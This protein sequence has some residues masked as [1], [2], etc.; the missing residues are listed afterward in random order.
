[1]ERQ[2]QLLRR[3]RR[4]E[5]ALRLAA[6]QHI[7]TTRFE[8][9][10]KVEGY[11]QD[12]SVPNFFGCD[13]L[14]QLDTQYG[15]IQMGYHPGRGQSFLFAHIK[16]SVLDSAPSAHQRRLDERSQ[17]RAQKTGNQNVAFS[18]RRQSAS[19][20]LL[21]KAENKPWS[22]ASLAPYL[23]RANLE[24]LA[25]TM[26]FLTRAEEA[27]RLQEAAARRRAIQD[28]ERAA[29][30]KG[31]AAALAAARLERR[32]LEEERSAL[33]SL[34]VRKHTQ[35]RLFFRK[36]NIAFDL[37]KAKLFAYYRRARALR[38][39]AAA[40]REAAA[41]SPEEQN[42]HDASEADN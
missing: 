35:S 36:L 27:R 40:A 12:R 3:S 16:T 33:Q 23:R 42:R 25:K 29:L 31:D 6:P 30:A 28:E 20:V 10:R 41:A 22:E 32:Q 19:A 5:T 14:W 26:P 38:A 2:E 37:Q 24:A 17:M 11:R 7:V 9:H 8:Q 4:R 1:M 39:E 15:R 18:A 34:L 13:K 21:Y